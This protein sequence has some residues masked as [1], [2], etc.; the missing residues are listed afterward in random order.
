[1]ILTFKT[2]II[3]FLGVLLA[4][5]QFEKWNLRIIPDSENAN[6][7]WLNINNEQLAGFEGSYLSVYKAAVCFIISQ[8][9]LACKFLGY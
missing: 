8:S 9:K 6:L 5:L 7:Y 3:M 1:M 4:P 2:A